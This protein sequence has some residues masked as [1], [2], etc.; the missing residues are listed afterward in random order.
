MSQPYN[1]DPDH[2]KNVILKAKAALKAARKGSG[3]K[4]YRL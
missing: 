1:E 3:C 4:Y 2:F